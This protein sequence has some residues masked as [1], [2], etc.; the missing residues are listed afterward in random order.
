MSGASYYSKGLPGEESAAVSDRSAVAVLISG[1]LDSSILLGELA[2]RHRTVHPLYVREG[3]RWEQVEL[4]H[5]QRYLRALNAPGLQPLSILEQPIWD[6]FEDHW[7]VTGEAVPDADSADEAVFLPA[8][9]ILLLAKAMLWCHLKRVPRVA[10]ATLH[11]NPFPDATVEFFQA[12]ERVVNQ[13]IGSAV[14]VVRPYGD[15][16]KRAVMARG[17]GLPLQF[18]FSCIRPLEGTHCGR[19]NKC[20]ERRQAFLAAGMDDPTMYAS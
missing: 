6:L 4:D 7:S 5:L 13:G 14:E 9:N 2:G 18:T 12:F 10:L 16:S 1:G 17:R 20:A 15:L 11:S 8:R 19:C 3:L